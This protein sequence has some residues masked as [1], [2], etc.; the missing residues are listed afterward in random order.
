[1]RLASPRSAALVALC[2]SRARPPVA[3]DGFMF[4]AVRPPDDNHGAALGALQAPLSASLWVGEVRAQRLR[5]GADYGVCEEARRTNST[6]LFVGSASCVGSVATEAVVGELGLD[7]AVLTGVARRRVGSIEARRPWLRVR[8]V[9]V[10]D[11]G[12]PGPARRGAPGPSAGTPRRGA[13]DAL[14]AGGA[15][16]RRAEGLWAE[17]SAVAR[18]VRERK[19]AA[20][21]RKLGGG[22]SAMLLSMPES[23]QVEL[24]RAAGR[25]ER[26]PPAARGGSAAAP[27]DLE[28]LLDAGVS[29][30]EEV[31][32]AAARARALGPA[33]EQAA[34]SLGSFVGLRLACGADEQQHE[35]AAACRDAVARW[36]EAARLVGEKLAEL[37]AVESLQLAAEAIEG[38]H[39][40]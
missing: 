10:A 14:A 12:T 30:A 2:A 5:G 16:R 36:E 1:M 37:R 20:R 34:L 22:A 13:E 19:L 29:L 4:T 26:R 28:A 32:R 33:D 38:A 40:E 3:S 15:C 7:R 18:R 8:A 23:E 27:P 24:S 21:L 39:G 6:L 11:D 31:E 35:W 9:R 17:A 25:D